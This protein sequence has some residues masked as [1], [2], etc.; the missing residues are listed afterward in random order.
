MTI[1]LNILVLL[2]DLAGDDD[3]KDLQESNADADTADEVHVVLGKV[4]DLGEAALRISFPS[5]SLTAILERGVALG[6][7]KDHIGCGV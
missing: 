3:A 2:R 5:R 4:L 6:V 7:L 1:K